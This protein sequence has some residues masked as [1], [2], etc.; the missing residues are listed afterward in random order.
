MVTI[1]SVC[2][3]LFTQTALAQL[4]KK[5]SRGTRRNLARVVY[6]RARRPGVVDPQPMSA[7][8]A[9]YVRRVSPHTGL[10]RVTRTLQM[11][12][13]PMRHAYKLHVP[14]APKRLILRDA[15]PKGRR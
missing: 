3:N 1:S 7:E 8:P 14:P 4:P 2:A 10:P 15:I 5:P 13:K 12:Q 9:P 11:N 6:R